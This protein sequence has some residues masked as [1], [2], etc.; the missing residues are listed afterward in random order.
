MIFTVK[1]VKTLLETDVDV[2]GGVYKEKKN[3]GDS[4]DM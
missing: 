4:G 3:N 1:D 2:V